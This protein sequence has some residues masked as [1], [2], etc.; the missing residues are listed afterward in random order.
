MFLVLGLGH[1]IPRDVHDA[2]RSHLWM[3]F[4]NFLLVHNPRGLVEFLEYG[5]VSGV[6]DPLLSPA[7]DNPLVGDRLIALRFLSPSILS[8]NAPC[9]ATFSHIGLEVKVLGLSG[10]NYVFVVPTLNK[11][12][13]SDGCHVA[14]S[15]T[16]K[17][18]LITL[19]A[20]SPLHSNPEWIVNSSRTFSHAQTL[21]VSSGF[22][23]TLFP[24]F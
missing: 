21:T 1:K 6:N 22:C 9:R 24:S 11:P 13:N 12:I 8:H 3:H 17:N 16:K 7:K 23:C 15:K 20:N 4:L 18:I 19:Q 10:R 14:A 2:C 5:H